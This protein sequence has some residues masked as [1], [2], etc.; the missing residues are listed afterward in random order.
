MKWFA[1]RSRQRRELRRK[2]PD[3][4]GAF[5]GAF[6]LILLLASILLGTS[7]VGELHVGAQAGA[8]EFMSA[9]SAYRS[10]RPARMALLR[11]DYCL[12]KFGSNARP[13]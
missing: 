2:P 9:W 10:M 3:V 8:A 7:L 1:A 5:F 13:R 4:Q 12:T 6:G 11:D